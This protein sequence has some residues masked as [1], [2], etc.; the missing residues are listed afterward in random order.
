MRSTKDQTGNTKLNDSEIPN[1]VPRLLKLAEVLELM[2]CSKTKFYDGMYSGHYPQSIE[3]L[4]GERQSLWNAEDIY[5]YLRSR[6]NQE[7]RK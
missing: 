2:R 6:V 1:D 5:D 7:G 4:P 3:K